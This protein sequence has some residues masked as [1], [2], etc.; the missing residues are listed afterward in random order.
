[1]YKVEYSLH[2]DKLFR[3]N[4]HNEKRPNM[5][6]YHLRFI[7][8][9]LLLFSCFF[10]PANCFD[11]SQESWG[12]WTINLPV[13]KVFWTSSHIHW[14]TNFGHFVIFVLDWLVL[15]C[16]V[17]TFKPMFLVHK[18]GKFII[19]MNMRI[20]IYHLSYPLISLS[21]IFKSF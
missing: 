1:M 14:P 17:Q 20:S 13:P 3:D 11:V 4:I 21:W 12:H 8:C 2:P 16:S 7:F 18:R 10:L 15:T 9:W 19:Y 5:Q 6:K